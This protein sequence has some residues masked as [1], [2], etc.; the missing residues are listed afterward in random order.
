MPKVWPR[1]EWR[2]QNLMRNPCF[3]PRRKRQIPNLQRESEFFPLYSSHGLTKGASSFSG[4]SSAGWFLTSGPGAW[5]HFF[6]D[7]LFCTALVGSATWLLLSGGPYFPHYT[8]F[9]S[10]E[11]WPGRIQTHSLLFPEAI[12]TALSTGHGQQLVVFC[13]FVCFYNLGIYM[14]SKILHSNKKLTLTLKLV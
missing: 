6:S 3:K 9:Q 5:F 13:L 11:R 7:L 4:L 14:L 8:Y 2:P 10:S 1:C 12:S